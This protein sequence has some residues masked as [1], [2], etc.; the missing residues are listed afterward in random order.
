MND[1]PLMKWGGIC[2]FVFAILWVIGLIFSLIAEGIPSQMP[3]VSEWGNTLT[4]G[5][6]RTAI[7]LFGIGM[8]FYVVAAYAVYDYLRKTS[9]GLSRTGFG[10]VTLFI[11]FYF[12]WF[13]LMAA[14]KNIVLSGASNYQT[15][16]AVIM[17]LSGSLLLPF[18]W[19]IVFY[20]FFWGLAFVKLAG[21]NKTVGFLSLATALISLLF[22][23]F[24][25][26]GNV[27]ICNILDLILI[28]V[29]IVANFFIGL[30][31]TAESKK[32]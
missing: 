6:Y 3:T 25:L 1:K 20:T 30:I 32:A 24:S 29:F 31:L 27:F 9:Y 16:L 23:V 14:G 28:I 10:F 5:T 19:F 22:Y 2:A 11:I 8:F 18:L 7:L 21:M 26:I 4:G 13:T 12:V 15:Q 17:N